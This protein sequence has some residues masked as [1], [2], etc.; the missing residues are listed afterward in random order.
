LDFGRSAGLSR[1]V[2]R[3][4]AETTRHPVRLDHVIR[5]SRVTGNL[6]HDAHLVALA[7]E[8]GVQ[9]I[10]TLDGDF[11]RFRQVTSRKPCPA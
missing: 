7:L 1:P 4:L 6:S 11:T 5:E 10:L 3:V 2:A 9:E 8:H